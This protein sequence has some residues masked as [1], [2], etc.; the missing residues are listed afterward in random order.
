MVS[1][2]DG[3]T[4]SAS[5]AG[6][7]GW[8]DPD[9][10]EVGNG[11]MSNTED[12]AQFSLWCVVAAP[13]IAGNNLTNMSQA[14][15]DTLTNP[16]VIAVDQDPAGVQGTRVTSAP[17]VG[18]NLEVWC[19]PLGTDLTAKA[20]ALFNR[21]STNA[22]IT[23][24]WCD[25][26]L[27]PGNATVRDLWARTDLG[28]FVNGYSAVVPTHGAELLKIIGT[29]SVSPTP[30]SASFTAAPTNGA[31]PLTVTFADTSTCSI[32]NW[33]WSFGDGN[34]TNATTKSMGHIYSTTGTYSVAETVTGPGG[35][36]TATRANYITVSLPPPSASFTAAPT[37]GVARLTVTFAD[38]S[39]GNIT[40][41]F[42]SF[43]DG[44]AT[45]ATTPGMQHAY[46]TAGNYTVTEIVTG[47]GGSSTATRVNYITILSPTEASQFQAWLSQ[48]FN[49]TNCVQSLMSFDADGTGQNNLFKF[50]AGL[51]PTNPTSVFVV[52]PA[53]VQNL[54]GTVQLPVHPGRS[55]PRLHPAVLHGLG[56]WR[57]VPAGGL[58]GPVINGAL[59][60]I[61][62][63]N[64]TQTNKF[65]RVGISLQPFAITSITLSGQNVN[66]A[67]NGNL[68]TN[69]VQAANVSYSSNFFDLA[70]IIM[71]SFGITNYTDSGAVTDGPSR[72]YR[73]DLR[74]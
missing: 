8:N 70:T 14:A 54:P 65:Y 64:V 16:E 9:M 43:G 53:G 68:G 28:T 73:I 55:R 24:N 47:L 11:G 67:W 29:G 12:Q 45:N 20:V 18:G 33:F 71:P 59:A 15:L 40:N 2:L 61:T 42:W 72:F 38:A 34:T 7:G 17:G 25:I 26:S 74:R 69:V 41:W 19:K 35:S 22:S 44:N 31:I 52:I 6:P 10:L 32:S 1:N 37:A 27:Q 60:T 62:D 49:C 5:A 50:V 57:V 21:S 66:L 56:E 30:P 48:Y 51:D 13:L 3:N 58:H 36:S 63:L 39:T 4:N 46:A 23:V